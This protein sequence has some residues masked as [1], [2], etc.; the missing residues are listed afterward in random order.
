MAEDYAV[1]GATEWAAEARGAREAP[2]A[3][4][5]CNWQTVEVWRE[6][7]RRWKRDRLGEREA[8][9]L[10]QMQSALALRRVPQERWPE[11]YAGLLV[12]EDEAIGIWTDQ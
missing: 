7:W 6:L 1:I 2:F 4:F 10:V 9:D 8:L 11:I 12:M 3:V 5:A